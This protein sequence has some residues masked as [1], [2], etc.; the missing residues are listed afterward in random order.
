MSGRTPLKTF[1]DGL[2]QKDRTGGQA[3]REAA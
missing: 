3:A 1:M 2:N